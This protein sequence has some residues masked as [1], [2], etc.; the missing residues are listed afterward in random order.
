MNNEAIVE[1]LVNNELDL[2]CL[3]FGVRLKKTPSSYTLICVDNDN[4]EGSNKGDILLKVPENENSMSNITA[5]FLNNMSINRSK[6]V[7]TLATPVSSYTP[8][9]K[10]K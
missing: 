5:F 2:M 10:G 3:I 1:Y 9:L 4:F 8:T 7:V 6:I